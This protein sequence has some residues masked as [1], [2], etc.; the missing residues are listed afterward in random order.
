MQIDI[1][2]YFA[3]GLVSSYRSKNIQIVRSSNRSR[4]L[5]MSSLTLFEFSRHVNNG[6]KLLLENGA[7]AQWN[8]SALLR[9]LETIFSA[10]K[11]G[12]TAELVTC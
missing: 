11:I 4:V 5:Q 1:C 3:G 8:I 7:E 12:V 6:I 2:L 10:V 9:S